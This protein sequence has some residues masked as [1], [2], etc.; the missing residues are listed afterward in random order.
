MFTSRV[1]IRI[2]D[3]LNGDDDD[4]VEASKKGGG[5]KLTN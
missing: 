1:V 3:V 4:N 5:V 2:K